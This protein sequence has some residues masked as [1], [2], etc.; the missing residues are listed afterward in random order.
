MVIV[1]TPSGCV[2]PGA[3]KKTAR[4]SALAVFLECSGEYL[5]QSLRQRL[6][7]SIKA[8]REGVHAV[9]CKGLQVGFKHD[10]PY[11]GKFSSASGCYFCFVAILAGELHEPQNKLSR[12]SDRVDTH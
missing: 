3:P 12:H 1:W 4:L 5:A 10:P 2:L 9:H 6:G 11:V 8:K 7:K